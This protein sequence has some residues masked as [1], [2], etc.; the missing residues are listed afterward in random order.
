MGQL[1]SSEKTGTEPTWIV[2]PGE[3]VLVT[4]SSGFIGRHV[5][6]L[7]IEKGLKNI[8][9]LA[10]ETSD[11][12]G[13]TEII[14]E[15]GGDG[16]ATIV[17][18]N[19]L[20]PDDCLKVAE[21]VKLIYH[22]AAGTGTKSFSEAYLNSVI[23]T[24]NLIEAALHHRCLKRFVNVSSF[25]VY[26]N[27][28]KKTGRPLDETCPV[29]TSPETRAEAYCYGKVKQDE[30]VMD[31][32][33]RSG[34]PYVIVRPGTVYGPGKK[35]IP[36]RVG[37][38]TF[39]VFLHFGGSNP[40]PLSYV[41]NCAEAIVLAGL[42]PGI[43]GEV[44]NIVDDHLPN[45]R[46][47]LRLYKK[48]VQNFR[49]IY[50]PKPFGFLF[51]FFWEKFSKWSGGQIPPVYT[52]REWEAYWKKTFYTNKKLKEKTGWSPRVTTADGLLAFF[53]SCRQAASEKH[54]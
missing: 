32:G 35:F 12:K 47:F 22:L 18:G 15:K 1:A 16:K 39:G 28:G 36:G 34:L 48:N 53:L 8:K 44:F 29:E 27:R 31:Y 38:D 52:L 7:L 13:L 10:R 43:D 54:K 26:T 23:T 24:R 6:G 49:S 9:C 41:E 19:L 11:I 46:E 30:L 20:S 50:I 5:V 14:K 17:Q 3:A 4:G 33:K 42:I 21:N 2:E 51:C 37:I 25:A 40:L 45:S